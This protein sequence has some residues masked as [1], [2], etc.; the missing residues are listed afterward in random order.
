MSLFNIKQ[1]VKNAV[2]MLITGNISADGED[3]HVK[4]LFSNLE[5]SIDRLTSPRLNVLVPSL[6]AKATFGG[7][8]TLVELPLLVYKNYLKAHGWQLRY[9]CLSAG[10]EDD[11][12]N[13]AIKYGRRHE[14]QDFNIVYTKLSSVPVGKQDVF[15]GS[16]WQ[17]YYDCIPLS[18]FAKKL[19]G[20]DRPYISF[21]QDYEAAFSPWSSA[22]MLAQSF[23]DA[24]KCITIFNSFELAD[25]Y[26]NQGH[27]LGISTNSFQPVMNERLR[28]RRASSNFKKKKQIVFYGRPQDRR[29]CFYIAKAA[30]EKWSE[31]YP[32]ASEWE[33]ISVGA[34][35][36]PLSLNNNVRQ[37][38]LGKL[39][40]D[41]YAQLLSDSSIGISLMASPH[42]SYPPLE[43][44]FFGAITLTNSFKN[45]DLSTWH[46]NIKSIS[47]I[48][49]DILSREI[50]KAC[51]AFNKDPNIGIKNKALKQSYI[52][53]FTPDVLSS[54][55]KTIEECISLSAT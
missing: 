44:A 37:K 17:N 45:K 41:D 11:N 43:M 16:L 12:D 38:I 39:S 51:D 28:A 2:R 52:E 29:N 10:T 22:Y 40:L 55:G 30:L 25:Y 23:Y 47:N 31:I 27:P 4:Y 32:T 20:A 48:N 21:V 15:M 6:S 35:H 3:E 46:E 36:A 33:V 24:A 14:I 18:D 34:P 13:V 54:I 19:S 53:D 50:C 49:P 42:P 8:A 7:V 26:K 1:R 9:I 5:P